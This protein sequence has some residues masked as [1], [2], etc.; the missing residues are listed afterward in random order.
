M[1]KQQIREYKHEINVALQQSLDYLGRN[2]ADII[3]QYH[4][5]N[6]VKTQATFHEFMISKH[7][8]NMDQPLINL[9]KK[10]NT[11][12]SP[13]LNYTSLISFAKE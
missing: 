4:E 7:Y 5:A 1:L 12:Q 10:G 6:K 9:I 3:N 11:S 13:C 2:M 8:D